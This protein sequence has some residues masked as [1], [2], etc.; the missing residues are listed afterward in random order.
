MEEVL[1]DGGDRRGQAGEEETLY[2]EGVEGAERRQ[3]EQDAT[4]AASLER[5][6]GGGREDTRRA[7][8]LRQSSSREDW[9]FSWPDSTFVLSS[10]PAMSVMPRLRLEPRISCGIYRQI[11]SVSRKNECVHPAGGWPPR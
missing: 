6:T 8:W 2:D 7:L 11:Q 1:D 3:T 9:I 5:W 4:E 10:S